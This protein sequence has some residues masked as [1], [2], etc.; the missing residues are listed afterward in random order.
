MWSQ[1]FPMYLAKGPLIT[2]LTTVLFNISNEAFIGSSL[3]SGIAE[4]SETFSVAKENSSI[5]YSCCP[6]DTPFCK[7]FIIYHSFS[8][9]SFIFIPFEGK[10]VNH[11]C[12]GSC[13]SNLAVETKLK[14]NETLPNFNLKST[15]NQS[16]Y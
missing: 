10:C 5:H 11:E 8:K 7:G 3:G 13:E 16:K 4:K 1:K 9:P 12:E 2:F 14:N 6:N 15:R